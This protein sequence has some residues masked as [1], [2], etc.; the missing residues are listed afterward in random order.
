MEEQKKYKILIVEDD[1][2]LRS[3]LAKKFIEEKFLVLEA[4]NGED[5]LKKSI[6]EHPDFILLDII[7]PV[8][9]GM[10]MLKKLREDDWGKQAKVMMLTNL[11]DSDK[12][13]Q[14]MEQNS[15]DYLVKTDWHIDEVVEK[16][17]EKL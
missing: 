17:K 2:V 6:S 13:S 9:D 5:G 11:S 1:K 10:T 16:V 14:A 7:M 15:Y 8:M 12:V 4:F 3:I